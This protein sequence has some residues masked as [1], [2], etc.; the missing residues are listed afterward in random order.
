IQIDFGTKETIT[1]TISSTHGTF[2]TTFITNTQVANTQ[3]IT[4][5]D[6]QNDIPGAQSTIIFQIK[7]DIIVVNPLSGFVGE[8]ITVEGRGY[9]NNETVQIDFGT[10][11]TIT[12]AIAGINGTFSVTFIINT[13]PAHTT[14]ITAEGLISGQ[15][16]TTNIFQIEPRFI[17]LTPCSGTVGTTITI[18][19]TGYQGDKTIRISF[20]STVTITTTTSSTNGTFST[21]FIINTQPYSSQTITARANNTPYEDSTTVF[22]ITTSRYINPDSGNVGST[23]SVY[24]A[25]YKASEELH[26]HFG[27]MITITTTTASINGSFSVTFMVNSQTYGT[28]Q[29]SVTGIDFSN[30]E[31]AG[32]YTIYPSLRYVAPTIG[33]VDTVVTIIAAG[34][35]SGTVRID[36]GSHNTITTATANGNGTFSITFIINSQPMNAKDNGDKVITVAGYGPEPFCTTVFDIYPKITLY[37]TSGH[38][39]TEVTVLGEG[40]YPNVTGLIIDFGTHFGL[41]P[42]TDQNPIN[43]NGT[44]SVTFIVNAQP[45]ATKVVTVRHVGGGGGNDRNATNTFYITG[46][47]INVNPSIGSVSTLITVIG[48][49]FDGVGTVTIDFGTHQTITTVAPSTNGTFSV[50]FKADV[51]PRG[52]KVITASTSLTKQ[53]ST[54]IFELMGAYIDF[55]SPSPPSSGPVGQMITIA[56]VGFHQNKDITVHFGTHE[57]ITTTPGNSNGTFS[58][59]FRV[60]TQPSCTKVITAWTTDGLTYEIATTTFKIQGAYITLVTPTSGSVGTI[61]TLEGVGFDGTQTITI[62]FGTNL[63]ITTTLP[64]TNGTFSTTFMVSS[65]SSGTKLITA[66][67]DKEGLVDLYAP[68]GKAQFKICNAYITLISP[69][70]G[71]VG[72]PITVHG[73]GFDGSKTVTIDFGTNLSIATTLSSDSGTFSVTFLIS[74]QFSGTKIITASSPNEQGIYR[75]SDG[76]SAILEITGAYLILVNPTQGSVTTLVALEGIGFDASTTVTIDFGTSYTITTTKS[77]LS[78]TFSITFK[79]DT[80]CWGTKGITASTS[81]RETNRTQGINVDQTT[82]IITDA[83]ILSVF[84]TQGTVSTMITVQ[85]IGFDGSKTV[86]IDFGTHYTITTLTSSPSGTFSITFLVDTQVYGTTYITASTDNQ[87]NICINYGRTKTTFKILSNII[88]YNPTEGSVTTIVTL[89]G[90]G[91]DGSTTV[92]IDFG[93]N[94]TITTT[95]STSNGTF[96]VTFRV[97]TQ[98]WG[99]KTITVRTSEGA[100]NTTTF[101]LTSAY[102]ILVNPTE[103]TVGTL[104]TISGV[105]FNGSKIITIDFGTH[106][107]ITT[108][109]SSESGTFSVTFLVSTQRYGS[110]R[111]TAHSLNQPN[112]NVSYEGTNTTFKILSEITL[113]TPQ[114]GSVSTTVTIIGR[115]YDG[116]TTVRI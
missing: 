111:I 35:S 75:Y 39:E 96:S 61:V 77:S 47:I 80:Q 14:V 15:R 109:T 108:T 114:E 41:A 56:G 98:S 107:T 65:Q 29:I 37:P 115:G 100:S 26:I 103:G 38:I 67:F 34:Y 40:Y 36:F 102:L 91:Y 88:T 62:H 2:S 17:T 6:V 49:G 113:F 55:I 79:V 105:G 32:T 83:Y 4:V 93:T 12:T 25:G 21:T 104:V 73:V 112:I 9:G 106:Y 81:P 11:Q 57:T 28:K 60:D 50:T 116:S 59:T 74:T 87:P 10:H 90:R 66:Y 42:Y 22:A 31:F 24:G 89:I 5:T 1:T 69:P 54:A 95:Q 58:V 99:T 43:A 7:A 84:P 63:S 76:T 86:T 53:S 101:M 97:D 64:S 18:E 94:Q 44:F 48:N 20:G 70:A 33:P 46:K 78:G 82:F 19:G 92:R 13:Q 30:T 51:Q 52:P 45:G 27:T 8:V 71:K 68:Q 85:G 110:H 23:V 72:A 3:V 16:A